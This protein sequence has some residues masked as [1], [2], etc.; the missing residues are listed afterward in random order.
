MLAMDRTQLQQLVR[1]VA[2]VSGGSDVVVI[3]SCAVLAAVTEP[4]GALV[5]GDVADVFVVDAPDA[6][7]RI[8]TA[9]GEGSM[10]HD[11]HG[12]CARA[13]GPLTALAPEGWADRIV[14]LEDAPARCMAIADLVLAKL[15]VGRG[16]DIDFAER[17][18]ELGVVDEGALLELVDRLPIPS[19]EREDVR[20]MIDRLHA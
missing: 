4:D 15:A 13:V 17:A 10:Y 9:L 7:E 16:K 14:P 11:E 5:P 6:G 18:L 19:H 12:V 20:R 1:N 8:D 3:G 2:R